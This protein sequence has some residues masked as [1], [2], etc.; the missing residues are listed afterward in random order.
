MIIDFICYL[1][2]IFIADRKIS[3]KIAHYTNFLII[4]AAVFILRSAY[5]STDGFGYYKQLYKQIDADQIELLD[6]TMYDKMGNPNTF[7][8]TAEEEDFE[9]FKYQLEKFQ[10]RHLQMYKDKNRWMPNEDNQNWVTS[11]EIMYY[12]K[13]DTFIHY[14]L[15]KEQ[16]KD[17]RK[18]LQNTD[19]KLTREE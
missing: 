8:K 3:F 9:S 4:V 14:Q 11:I 17:F 10:D 1:V 6:Y 12:G 19:I 13:K 7:I 16:L 15:T 5:I 2:A 18:I